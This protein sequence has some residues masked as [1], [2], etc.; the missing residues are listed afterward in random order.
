MKSLFVKATCPSQLPRRCGVR[1]TSIHPRRSGAI[2]V[3][4]RVERG[5][6][7][8]RS[9]RDNRRVR[10]SV[11]AVVTAGLVARCGETHGGKA[12]VVTQHGG[13]VTKKMT[14]VK[15]HG[16]EQLWRTRMTREKMGTYLT[17][18]LVGMST[19]AG[20]GK[21]NARDGREPPA[22]KITSHGKTGQAPELVDQST[23]RWQSWWSE[24]CE[25]ASDAD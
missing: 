5:L 16:K 15:C 6:P 12:T 8:P 23:W 21:A 24:S 10:S 25:T 7:E 13:T 22:A 17:G 4:M 1:R 20:H 18:P 2:V 9:R 14:V 3:T 19:C 11:Q